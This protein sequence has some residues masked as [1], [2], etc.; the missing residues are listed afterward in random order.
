MTLDANH[1]QDAPGTLSSSDGRFSATP[2]RPI[3][4]LWS[5]PLSTLNFG[6]GRTKN[7]LYMA[8]PAADGGAEPDV[9]AV[10]SLMSGGGVELRLLRG[11]PPVD[12]GRSDAAP[13]SIGGPVF[14]VF[15]LSLQDGTCASLLRQRSCSPDA[16]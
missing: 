1:L 3:P 8:T 7:L 12:A 2:L 9:T 14:G 16:Q 11:A 4:Q 6:E 13:L 10:V 5:D 15:P